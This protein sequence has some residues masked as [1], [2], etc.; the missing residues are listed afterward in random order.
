M[1]TFLREW[2]PILISLIVMVITVTTFFRAMKKDNG[3]DAADR[4][5][6]S[7]DLMHIRNTV[8]EIKIE[9]RTDREDIKELETRVARVEASA[10]SAHKRLDDLRKGSDRT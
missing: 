1:V 7:A 3:A 10:A 4:A 6:M 8:D 5:K 9:I 2:G